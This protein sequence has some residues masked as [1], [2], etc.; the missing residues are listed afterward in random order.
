MEEV[1]AFGYNL[2]GLGKEELCCVVPVYT[3]SG[4]SKIAMLLTMLFEW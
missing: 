4:H 1:G 2:I 3:I